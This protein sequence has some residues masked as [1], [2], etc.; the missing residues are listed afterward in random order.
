MRV[1]AAVLLVCLLAAGPA[2]A[3]QHHGGGDGKQNLK[4][5]NE[6]AGE[7]KCA[8]AVK[9][10]TAAYEKLRDPIVL[11]NRGECY[12][13]LGENAKA[14]EDYRGFLEGF[15]GA[16]NRADIEARIATLEKPAAPPP[17]KVVAPVA[18]P[19]APPVATRST[20]PVPPPVRPVPPPPVAAAPPPPPP[21]A[22]PK[23]E[24]MPFLPLPPPAQGE[25]NLLVEAKP[26]TP[27][28]TARDENHG[29]HWLL[30]TTLAVV[31]VGGGVAGYV[32]LRPKPE[33]LPMTDYGNYRF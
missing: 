25:P 2:S 11:F 19:T 14:A 1:P 23:P 30:W 22:A 17:A 26:T 33:A 31:A 28:E 6:L 21:A 29:S 20:A 8:A 32:F 10:Y 5:A 9:E 24:A 16:P 27:K 15:P 13:R 3:R 12:R 18:R 4:R 7:G